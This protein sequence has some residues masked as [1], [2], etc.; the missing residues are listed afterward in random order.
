MPQTGSSGRS[1]RLLGMLT[2]PIIQFL[3]LVTVLA[4]ASAV[5]F[6]QIPSPPQIDDLLVEASKQRD[7]YIGI[8]QD[9][10]ANETK[11]FQTFNDDGDAKK[12]RV[13]RSN[14]IIYR[15]ARADDRVVEFRNVLEVDGKPAGRTDQRAQDF[16]EKLARIEDSAKELERIEDE[17]FRYDPGIRISGLTLFQ[18]VTLAENIRPSIN[19]A[20]E[21]T[22]T[23]DGDEVIVVAFQQEQPNEYI[24]VNR[25]GAPDPA[26]T[27]ISYEIDGRANEPLNERIRGKFW[28]DA[29]TFQIRRE[30]R[31]VT[32]KPAD[33]PQPVMISRTDATYRP[34]EYGILTPK[35][36]VHELYQIKRKNKYLSKTSR[37][38]SSILRF[39]RP[40]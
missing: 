25:G 19:F 30:L 36:I 31:E 20:I 26:K 16:F 27:A 15:L 22:D 40:T 8:F 12:R 23:I 29:K 13:V 35:L 7:N 4:T 9:L 1:D 11:R 37:R 32:V 39:Q 10:L 2:R 34:S 17:S 18:G 21:G 6:S 14:L 24:R 28:L 3:A 38:P 33:F 5:T